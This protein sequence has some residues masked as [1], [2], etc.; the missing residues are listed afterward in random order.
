MNSKHKLVHFLGEDHYKSPDEWKI[1]VNN[2]T[3]DFSIVLVEEDKEIEL[4]DMD[5][6]PK[7]INQVSNLKLNIDYNTENSVLYKIKS[8]NKI[9]FDIRKSLGIPIDPN[10]SIIYINFIMKSLPDNIS[11]QNN[12]DKLDEHL[13]RVENTFKSMLYNNY[14][15]KLKYPS[16]YYLNEIYTLRSKLSNEEYLYILNLYQ[17]HNKLCQQKSLEIMN[18]QFFINE[19]KS[20]IYEKINNVIIDL[21]FK[22][23]EIYTDI[24]TLGLIIYYLKDNNRILVV[25]GLAHSNY[26]KEKLELLDLSVNIKL[27]VFNDKKT[28]Y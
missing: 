17:N 19:Y 2:L 14:L 25:S 10:L 13:E 7:E 23:P 5:L 26:L 28:W 12:I 18:N 20:N 22:L 21:M 15:H 1:Y 8:S 11:E 24:Y 4:K 27:S 9:K 16:E 6:L 3:K